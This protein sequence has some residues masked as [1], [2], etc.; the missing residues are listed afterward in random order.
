MRWSAVVTSVGIA[1]A[2]PAQASAVGGPV[3]PV[4]GGGGVGA[5]GSPIRLVAQ[6]AGR[7]TVVQRVTRGP[8]RVRSTIRLPGSWGVPGADFNG[9]TT[10]LSADG[11]TLVLEQVTSG[12]P[13]RTTRLLELG[14]R[15]LAVRKA[16]VLPGWSTVDAISPDG[17]WMYIIHYRSS[18]ISKYEVLAYDLAHGRL[19]AKPI[20]D[21]R[22]RGEQMAG[23]PVSRV[24]SPDG[25]WAYT[26]YFRPSDVPF[27]HALDTVGLRAVCIDLPSVGAGDVASDRLRLGPGATVLGVTSAGTVQAAI[28][29]RTFAIDSALAA[30]STPSTR[31]PSRE[32]RAGGGGVP[33]ELVVLAIAVLAA[34]GIGVW[35]LPK[36]RAA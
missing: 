16:I 22:D 20:V 15:P 36:L 35:R 18:D 31:P 2:M 4:Q 29:T 19:L 8:W 9:S 27:V 23:F 6:R 1:L 28:N 11:R 33:W 26:L 32:Q 7:D 5:A 10:G 3:A 30:V 21:P 13:V 24:M 25:R 12:Y 34:L 14:V 17:R